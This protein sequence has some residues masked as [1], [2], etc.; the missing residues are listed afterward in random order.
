[1]NIL[2]ANEVKKHGVTA[3]EK[4][5]KKGPVHILKH[6]KPLFVVLTEENYQ[7]LSANQATAKSGLFSLL[8]KPAT[9]TRSRKSIDEQIKKD[10][11]N[12]EK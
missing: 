1:M 11:D 12:W 4:K 6:N 5:I 2:L 8:A 10:R 3:I 7:L 9:G